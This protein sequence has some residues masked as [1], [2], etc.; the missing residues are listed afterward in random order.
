MAPLAG[1]GANEPSP[2]TIRHG[3]A[4]SAVLG[5]LPRSRPPPPPCTRYIRS[6]PHPLRTATTR[7]AAS[8]DNARFMFDDSFPLAFGPRRTG[9]VRQMH[10]APRA[11]LRQGLHLLR[12]ERSNS[13]GIDIG[14]ITGRIQK[15]VRTGFARTNDAAGRTPPA[16]AGNVRP[17]EIAKQHKMENSVAG[18]PGCRRPARRWTLAPQ[19]D[20]VKD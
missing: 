2:D 18:V 5:Q 7:T 8:I 10:K 15:I 14:P 16:G 19:A 1:P 20:T 17:G 12:P 13:P 9:H 11:A 4:V 6:W 3:R